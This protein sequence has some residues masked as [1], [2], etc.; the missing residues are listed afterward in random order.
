MSM[1]CFSDL[2]EKAAIAEPHTALHSLSRQ[3]LGGLLLLGLISLLLIGGLGYQR[4]CEKTELYLSTQAESIIDK[5]D[6]NLFERYAYV[7]AYGFYDLMIAVVIAERNMKRFF[8]IFRAILV[9]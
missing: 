2:K 6:R 9:K 1:A 8:L 4:L 3:L 7:R 5:I